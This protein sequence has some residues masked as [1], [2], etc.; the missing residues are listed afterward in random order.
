MGDLHYFTN[1]TEHDDVWR[2]LL[3]ITDKVAED[4]KSHQ[5]SE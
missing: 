3:K 1:L 2:G 4:E 5:F